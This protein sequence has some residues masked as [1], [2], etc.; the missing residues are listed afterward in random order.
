VEA[1]TK[2]IR[3]MILLDAIKR[4]EGLKA[5]MKN[6][7]LLDSLERKGFIIHRPGRRNWAKESY[8]L[9]IKAEKTLEEYNKMWD[10]RGGSRPSAGH[11]GR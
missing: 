9:T 5:E 6:D 1:E 10:I 7:R 4:G 3:S 11:Q 2:Y 8:D